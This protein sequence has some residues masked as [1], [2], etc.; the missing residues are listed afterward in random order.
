MTP[1]A[2]CLPKSVEKQSDYRRRDGRTDRRTNTV[3]YKVTFLG[4]K[5]GWYCMMMLSEYGDRLDKN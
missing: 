1:V 5:M 3:T 4:L 2:Y